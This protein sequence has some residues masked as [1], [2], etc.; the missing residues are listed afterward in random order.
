MNK[1]IMYARIFPIVIMVLP[2]MIVGITF[3]F[4]YEKY[5]HILTTL[6]VGTAIV[7]LLGNF[8]RDK[9]KHLEKKLWDAWGGAPSLQLLDFNNTTID[10]IT[11]K[12]YHKRLQDLCPVPVNIDYAT[13]KWEECKEVYESWNKYLLSKTRDS[14]AFEVLYEENINYGFRRNMLGLK[15]ESITLLLC[16]L[17]ANYVFYYV[18]VKSIFFFNYPIEFIVSE[19]VNLLLLITWILKINSN[20]VKVPAFA[21]AQRLLESIDALENKKEKKND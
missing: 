14:K 2:L 5:I 15:K 3:T 9:G 4:Q 6:G 7:Y 12:R 8:A 19:S 21:Y 1:Y 16:I 20:W 17:I 11:K 18:K 10:P 13:A